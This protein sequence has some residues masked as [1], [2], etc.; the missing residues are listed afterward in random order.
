MRSES[1][2]VVGKKE[3]KGRG[4]LLLAIGGMHGNERAGLEAFKRIFEALNKDERPFYGCFTALA[5]NLKALELNTRY[6][7]NDLNRIWT[8][9][10]LK[11]AYNGL[12]ESLFP[13]HKELLGLHQTIENYLSMGYERVALIDL[14]TT[15]AMGGVFIVCPDE[16]GHKRMITRLH[17]PVILNL[18]RDL[19][20]TAMQ[21]FWDRHITAFAFE[22]GSHDNPDSIDKM[23]SALWLCLEYMGCIRRNDF[24]EIKFHDERLKKSTETLPHFCHLLHHHLIEEGDN[25]EMHEGF[26]NFQ[27]ISKGQ[28]LA[29]DKHGEIASPFDGFILMP[30]YQKKGSDGFFIV[31]P[32]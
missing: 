24:E 26:E 1:P 21:Y 10:D 32:E 11:L 5:G 23:E 15:S 3:G 17:V 22:G 19:K 27:R 16:E 4:Q 18:D 9:S 7:K 20:G 14:H 13:E 31:Y 28:P 2:H 6:L 8:E 29:R 30:L 25:F 12:N